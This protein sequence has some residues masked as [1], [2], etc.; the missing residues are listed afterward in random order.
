MAK[1]KKDNTVLLVILAAGGIGLYYYLKNS[2]AVPAAAV[3]TA[4]PGSGASIAPGVQ[5]PDA[6][7]ATVT[8]EASGGQYANNPAVIKWASEQLQPSDYARFTQTSPGFTADEWLGLYRLVTGDPVYGFGT[9]G[10]GVFWNAW[11]VKYGIDV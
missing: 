1:K 10:G 8:G 6:T 2:A 5:Q 3:T 9:A 4:L 11:R 7:A